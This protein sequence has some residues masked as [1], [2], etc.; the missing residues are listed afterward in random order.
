MVARE[1]PR[2]G[3]SLRV[4][5]CVCRH[6]SKVGFTYIFMLKKAKGNGSVGVNSRVAYN[7]VE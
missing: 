2:T 1:K 5:V 4:L 3:E 6:E 7:W